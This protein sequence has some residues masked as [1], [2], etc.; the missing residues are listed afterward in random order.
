MLVEAVH[1]PGKENRMA[2]AL[3]RN[4]ILLFLQAFLGAAKSPT[5][6]PQAGTG[7]VSGGT[8]RLDI[9][10]VCQLYRQGLAQSTQLAYA[11][12]KRCYLNFCERLGV[13]TIS[14]RGPAVG[15]LKDQS[16]RHQIVK[17][18]LSAVCHL[19]ISQGKETQKIRTSQHWIW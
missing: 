15:F 7:T 18:Y 1:L 4:N 12:G 8:A 5:H 19:L 10:T 2:D 11:L 16:L 13:S 14:H 6:L 9:T 17:S 3:S